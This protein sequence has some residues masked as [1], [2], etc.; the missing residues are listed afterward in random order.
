MT[1]PIYAQKNPC[2]ITWEPLSQMD[3]KTEKIADY[4][5]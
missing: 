4:N 3:L 1:L 5:Q 2:Y